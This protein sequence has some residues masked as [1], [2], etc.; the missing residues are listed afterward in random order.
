MLKLTPKDYAELTK[1][2]LMTVYT[3]I[4]KGQLQSIR[5]AGKI[6]IIL[7]EDEEKL[8]SALYF[9]LRQAEKIALKLARPA[10]DKR[11]K[12]ENGKKKIR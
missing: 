4:Y 6:Y 2:P 12:L 10:I 11:R 8:T 5:E 9:H 1:T 7:Q 3:W